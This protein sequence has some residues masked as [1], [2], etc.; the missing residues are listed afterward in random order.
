MAA[1][2]CARG[3]VTTITGSLL[4][5]ALLLLLPKCPLCLAAWLTV[6]TGISISAGAAVWLR[7]ILLLSCILAAAALIWRRQLRSR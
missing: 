1:P 7:E 3:R 2:C 4:P 6:A 5:G